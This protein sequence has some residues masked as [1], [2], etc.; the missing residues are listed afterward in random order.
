MDINDDYGFAVYLLCGYARM[1]FGV[2]ILRDFIG[3]ML[4]SVFAYFY[5][6]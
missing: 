4:N 2:G 3:E 6:K 5:A 1:C